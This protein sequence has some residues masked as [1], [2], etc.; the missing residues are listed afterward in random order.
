MKLSLKDYL[1]EYIQNAIILT[2]DRQVITMV[3]L[4]IAKFIKLAWFDEQFEVRHIVKEVKQ[5]TIE[6]SL[7]KSFRFNFL[8]LF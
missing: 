5:I 4:L 8:I 3:L 7:I 2:L 1:V 6:V